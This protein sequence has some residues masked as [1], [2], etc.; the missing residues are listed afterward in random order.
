MAISQNISEDDVISEGTIIGTQSGY[1]K[2]SLPNDFGSHLHVE[3]H[4]GE[5]TGGASVAPE[6][7]YSQLDNS[8]EP[9]SYLGAV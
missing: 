3:I 6:H 8:V 1:G 2:N 4:T 5:H 9:Y 7:S